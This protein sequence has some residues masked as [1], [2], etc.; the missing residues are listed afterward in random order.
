[1][2]METTGQETTEVDKDGELTAPKQ[3]GLNVYVTKDGKPS[4]RSLADFIFPGGMWKRDVYTRM[5]RFYH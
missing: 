3:E 2:P 1:M 4:T 5:G